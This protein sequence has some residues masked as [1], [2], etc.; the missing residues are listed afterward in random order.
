MVNKLAIYFLGFMIISL[1]LFMIGTLVFECK[2]EGK[3]K[4][5]ITYNSGRW[6]DT[7]YTDTFQVNPGPSIKYINEFG[8]E[9]TRYGTYSIQSIK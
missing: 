7:E 5:K 1:I 3:Y 8:K 4:Y 2:N 6:S 9:I